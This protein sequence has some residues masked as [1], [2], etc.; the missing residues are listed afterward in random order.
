MDITQQVLS[1]LRG[2]RS[3]VSRQLR[4]HATAIALINAKVENR[5][6][7]YTTT[8]GP[9]SIGTTDV[10]VTWPRPFPD[11]DYWVGIQVVSSS[12]QLGN[13]HTTLKA[14]TRTATGCVV[15]VSTAANVASIA[16]D[17]IGTRT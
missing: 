1:A 14:G 15:T 17:V 5:V 8:V 3:S 13:I 6:Q 12:G 10:T 16:V 9:L 7:R 4:T 11:A 2:W